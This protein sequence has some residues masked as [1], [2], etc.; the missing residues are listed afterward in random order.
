V[1]RSSQFQQHWVSDDWGGGPWAVWRLFTADHE[2][3]YEPGPAPTTW[4]SKNIP[5]AFRTN[6][7][8]KGQQCELTA[9]ESALSKEKPTKCSYCSKQ[10]RLARNTPSWPRSWAN[11]SLL[12]L[13]SHRNAWANL[14]LL[15]QSDTFLAISW[16]PRWRWWRRRSWRW[17]RGRGSG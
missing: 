3:H 11:F 5:C 6:D 8:T 16:R 13:Y 14:H 17:L 12:Q 10:V 2:G 1:E 7:P 4:N 9:E 15:G